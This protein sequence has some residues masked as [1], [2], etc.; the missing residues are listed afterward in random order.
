M[1]YSK[2]GRYCKLKSKY[3]KIERMRKLCN[4]PQRSNRSHS[5]KLVHLTSRFRAR[6]ELISSW[7]P[8]QASKALLETKLH[9]NLKIKN[10]KYKPIC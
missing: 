10:R 8:A 2:Q 1:L 9:I 4:Y 5:Q 6:I 7:E 3:M